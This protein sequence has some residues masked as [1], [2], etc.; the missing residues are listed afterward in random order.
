[1]AREGLEVA[2]VFRHF[3]PAFRNQHGVSLS[4]AR[5]H[6]MTAI[7]SCRTA[8]LGGHVEQFRLTVL[9][10]LGACEALAFWTMAVPAGV[11]GDTLMPAVTTPLNMAAESGGTATLDR[12]HGASPG[13]G[14]RRAMLITERRAEVAE[15]IRH[16][17]PLAGHGNRASGGDE[18]RHDRCDVV[19]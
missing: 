9:K 19:Q 11:I 5:R 12:D 10:P 17:Q 14:Q 16:L 15:H 2:D 18:I 4:P 13:S 6:A 8:A 1:M 3:G 7:E